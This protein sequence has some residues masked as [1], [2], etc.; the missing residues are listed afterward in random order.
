[1]VLQENKQELQ[2]C[3]TTHKVDVIIKFCEL[4][5]KPR[6]IHYFAF[7]RQSNEITLILNWF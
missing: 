7:F 3:L 2:L 5:N 6:L 4:F 1:M